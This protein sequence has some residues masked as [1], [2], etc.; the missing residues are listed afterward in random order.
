MPLPA[1]VVLSEHKS[2]VM[3]KVPFDVSTN[4][5]I[6]ICFLSLNVINRF[7]SVMITKLK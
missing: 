3:L 4:T 6:T 5:A 7:A 2:D 1:E